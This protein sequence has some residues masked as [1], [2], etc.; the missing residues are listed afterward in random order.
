MLAPKLLFLAQPTWGV[1]IGAAAAI[2]KRA[3]QPSQ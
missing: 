1:D 2:R 3:H